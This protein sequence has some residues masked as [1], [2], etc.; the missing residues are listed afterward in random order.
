M[1]EDGRQVRAAGDTY[2]ANG[3]SGGEH[4]EAPVERIISDADAAREVAPDVAEDDPELEYK[5]SVYRYE[6]QPE[7]AFPDVDFTRS[8]ETPTRPTK[9]GRS[10]GDYLTLLLLIGIPIAIAAILFAVAQNN[11]NTAQQN[12]TAAPTPLPVYYA[13]RLAIVGHDENKTGDGTVVIDVTLQNHGDSKVLTANVLVR[14]LDKSGAQVGTGIIAIQNI[15]AGAIGRG[16]TSIK[17]PRDYDHVEYLI[18]S[19]QTDNMSP[20]NLAP[21]PT[22]AAP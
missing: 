4:D 14:L 6:E 16:E 7:E 17:P 2:S 22:L 15:A 13:D 20:A 5:L 18:S 1:G 10:V 21:T 8:G 9:P 3:S 11:R 12:A 19:V